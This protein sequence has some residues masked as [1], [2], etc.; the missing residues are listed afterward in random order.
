MAR[1]QENAR[2]LHRKRA[3][4]EQCGN[5]TADRRKYDREYKRM[6]RAQKAA[7]EEDPEFTLRKQEEPLH[8]EPTESK[9]KKRSLKTAEK[10]EIVARKRVG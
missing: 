8:F 10:A 2:R 1:L 3:N 4:R 7:I 9:P 5:K 6:R